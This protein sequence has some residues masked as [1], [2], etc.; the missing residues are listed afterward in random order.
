MYV[1]PLSS[2]SCFEHD[3]PSTDQSFYERLPFVL[4]EEDSTAQV[5]QSRNYDQTNNVI[6]SGGRTTFNTRET[7]LHCTC[8]S[9]L[10]LF[11]STRTRLLPRFS[12]AT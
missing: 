2:D 10:L 12:A 4:G 5:T 9:A 8:C 7:K 3:F 1:A 6:E 11:V